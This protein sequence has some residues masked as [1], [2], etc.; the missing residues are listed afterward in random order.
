MTGLDNA[1]KVPPELENLVNIV[2]LELSHN[3]LNG[4]AIRRRRECAEPLHLVLTTSMLH[5]NRC[6]WRASKLQY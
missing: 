2:D 6:C 3:Q 1:G 4:E 5:V